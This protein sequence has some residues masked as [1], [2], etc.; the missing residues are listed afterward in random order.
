MAHRS[1]PLRGQEVRAHRP[2]AGEE[3]LTHPPM[4]GWA[5]EAEKFV[6]I[7]HLFFTA[8]GVL[9]MGYS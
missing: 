5:L 8:K 4:G 1:L 2:E 3:Q 9:G 7:V 6:H